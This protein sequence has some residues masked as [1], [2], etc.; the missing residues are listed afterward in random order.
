MIKSMILRRTERIAR[1]VEIKNDSRIL[2]GT[3]EEGKIPFGR[4]GRY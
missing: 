4:L 2:V 3:L 1:M